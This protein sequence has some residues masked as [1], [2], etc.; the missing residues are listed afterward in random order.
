LAFF[1]G[2]GVSRRGVEVGVECVL[3][4]RL[5][6]GDPGLFGLDCSGGLGVL[7][8]GLLGDINWRELDC[9]V[10][11]GTVSNY[12]G[13]GTYRSSGLLFVLTIT[14]LDL[15]VFFFSSD[16]GFL[17]AVAAVVVG[18]SLSQISQFKESYI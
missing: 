4:L 7:S 8:T 16:V 10:T 13:N 3:L 15:V 14:R 11:L 6:E 5:G 9:G 12:K 1:R 2:E 18:P 17:A